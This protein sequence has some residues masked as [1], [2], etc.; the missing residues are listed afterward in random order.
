MRIFRL[1]LLR[2]AAAGVTVA[3]LW[4]M[5]DVLC[6]QQLLIVDS[7]EIKADALVVLGGGSGERPVRAVEL[8]QAGAAPKILLSGMGDCDSNAQFLVGKG[9]P[10]AVITR[11]EHAASTLENAKFSIPLLRQ[12]GAH[13][14]IIV[15]TWYHSRRALA[16]FEHF[17]PDIKFYSRPSYFGYPR[18]K[19]DRRGAGGD[20]R[21]EFAKLSGYSVFYGVWPYPL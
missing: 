5:A 17:A 12:M 7:G 4:G 14:V 19:L 15:T 20:V 3:V 10:A 18:Q 1:L 11:E 8:F 9:V 6:P 2:A 13:R 21:A 16:C